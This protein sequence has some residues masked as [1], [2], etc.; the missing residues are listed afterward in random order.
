[1][2]LARV[3]GHPSVG[4]A[5]RVRTFSRFSR[6]LKSN[7][8]KDKNSTIFVYT[9]STSWNGSTIRSHRTTYD[10]SLDRTLHYQY[11]PISNRMV[12]VEDTT[13]NNGPQ[14]LEI[15]PVKTSSDVFDPVEPSQLSPLTVPSE[16]ESFTAPS[17]SSIP[18]STSANDDTNIEILTANQIRESMGK[19]TGGKILI[20]PSIS[21]LIAY[22]RYLRKCL[23]HCQARFRDFMAL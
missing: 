21:S 10:S 9:S 14:N 20:Q 5:L 6:K 17:R 15:L 13:S 3:G 7:G 23:C 11:D 19:T 22:F 18:E 1:M 16:S 2:M 12:K 4:V 8:P